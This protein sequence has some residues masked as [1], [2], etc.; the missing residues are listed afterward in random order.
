[1]Y[2]Q[3]FDPIMMDFA[4]KQMKQCLVNIKLNHLLSN[5]L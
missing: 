5:N 1:M 2:N 4:L 3:M